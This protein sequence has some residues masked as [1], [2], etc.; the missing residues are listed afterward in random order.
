ML[1]QASKVTGLGLGAL[2][3]GVLIVGAC[4]SGGGDDDD[5]QSAAGTSSGGTNNG[6]AGGS[7]A[8]STTAGTGGNT[9]QVPVECVGVV[10]PTAS[11]A[12][13]DMT[14]AAGGKYEWGS[15][16]QG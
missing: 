10:P 1:S 8:G 5:S 9:T 4:G 3:C 12:D 2:L 16:E 11:I 7:T 14:P 13:F 6:G 15:A